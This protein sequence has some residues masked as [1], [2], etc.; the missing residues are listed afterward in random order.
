MS[1]SAL[2]RA[3]GSSG[4]GLQEDTTTTPPKPLQ[5]SDPEK[6]IAVLED[7][8]G[9]VDIEAS[10]PLPNPTPPEWNRPRINAFRVAAAFWGFMING[11]HDACFGVS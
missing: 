2:S 9:V 1:L 3:Y 11:M 7:A 6:K 5:N 4:R 8:A 10:E